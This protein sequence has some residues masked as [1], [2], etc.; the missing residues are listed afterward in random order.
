MNKQNWFSIGPT[1]YFSAQKFKIQV[2]VSIDIPSSILGS[3]SHIK[4][5]L[6]KQLFAHIQALLST[7]A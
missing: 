2:F 3:D 5:E 7:T 6:E 4:L 1:I